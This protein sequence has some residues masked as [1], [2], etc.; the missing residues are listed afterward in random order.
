MGSAVDTPTS[1][2]ARKK[3]VS[4]RTKPKMSEPHSA[5]KL[6]DVTSANAPILFK[7]KTER[8]K[9]AAATMLRYAFMD[10]GSMRA[11]CERN[12][13][14]VEAQHNAE[15]RPAMMPRFIGSWMVG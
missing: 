13:T 14:V 3:S 8:T 2:I 5:R 9:K 15:M 6:V 12:M 7:R 10:S 4:P 11:D 1:S